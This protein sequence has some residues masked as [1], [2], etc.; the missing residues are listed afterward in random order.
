[1]FS[2]IDGQFK[3]RRLEKW[4][5]KHGVE[6]DRLVFLEEE[7]KKIEE[8]LKVTEFQRYA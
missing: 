7:L 4:F 2:S 8:E 6:P 3:K 5:L 1:M